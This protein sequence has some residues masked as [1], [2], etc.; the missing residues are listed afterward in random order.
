[1]FFKKVFMD[2][3][4]SLSYLIGC[5]AA[6]KACVIDPMRGVRSYIEAAQQHGME[7][8]HIIDTNVSTQ[9]HQQSGT[10]ELKFR[11]DAD[12]YY[13]NTTVDENNHQ[14]MIEGDFIQLGNAVI[15]V[16]D[17]PSHN[18]F[19]LSVRVRDAADFAAPWMIL[20][21]EAL[22]IGDLAEEELTGDALAKAVVCYLDTH[23]DP[24]LETDCL[25]FNNYSNMSQAASYAYSPF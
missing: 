18:P 17:S 22:F 9:Q 1:M 7:I 12:L 3:K 19:G 5:T 15:E 24:S 23:T 20:S 14:Q 10:M 8:T 11:T 2:D 16:I 25:P 6:K 13:L 21:S 4:G